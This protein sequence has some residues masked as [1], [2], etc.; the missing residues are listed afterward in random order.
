MCVDKH[1]RFLNRGMQLHEQKRIKD[2][3]GRERGRERERETDRQT[4][5]ERPRD[6]ERRQGK[7]N[8]LLL[9][10]KPCKRI[11]AQ[12]NNNSNKKDRNR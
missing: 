8:R 6:T 7:A 5:T 4:E 11:D 3:I 12:N 2:K 9:V 1:K 10:I